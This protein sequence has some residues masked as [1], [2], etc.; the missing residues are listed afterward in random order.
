MAGEGG[1]EEEG[2]RERSRSGPSSCPS[3]GRRRRGRPT[4]QGGPSRERPAAA[5]TAAGGGCP[6]R[7]SGGGGSAGGTQRRRARPAGGQKTQSSPPLRDCSPP[8]HR[9]T[10][11]LCR[12]PPPRGGDRRAGAALAARAPRGRGWRRDETAPK[13]KLPAIRRCSGFVVVSYTLRVEI[14]SL[15]SRCRRASFAAAVRA[16]PLEDASHSASRTSPQYAGGSPYTHAH[17]RKRCS[18]FGQLEGHECG[19]RKRHH[20]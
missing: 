14:Y 17:E 2:L 9:P 16:D 20:S 5:A 8:T 18:H 15:E 4:S 10:H 6:R 1:K 11:R 19:K 7:A 13:C 12:P 3:L